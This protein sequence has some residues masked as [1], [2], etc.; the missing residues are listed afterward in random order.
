MGCENDNMDLV[1]ESETKITSKKRQI[2][3]IGGNRNRYNLEEFVAFTGQSL[4][5]ELTNSGRLPRQ[6]IAHNFVLLQNGTNID[7]FCTKAIASPESSYIP[8]E[9]ISDILAY[10]AMAGPKE[11]VE[12]EFTAP[13]EP[14]RYDY[15]C[16]FPGHYKNGMQGVFTVITP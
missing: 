15:V 14:G 10:T 5:I 9:L 3:L 8:E 11:T 1:V 13:T 12:V 6:A 2:H 16:T 7:D 4:K